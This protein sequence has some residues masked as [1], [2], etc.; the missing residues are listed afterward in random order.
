M[1]DRLSPEDRSRTMRAVKGKGTSLERKLWS[2]LA[3]MKLKGWRKNASCVPG[4]PDVAFIDNKIALFVDG[5][6]WHGCPICNRPMPENN[7]QYWINKIK[8]NVERDEEVNDQ[9]NDL[10]WK[11]FRIWEHE[12]KD[13]SLR[14]QKKIRLYSYFNDKT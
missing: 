10:G 3:G 8:R 13:A 12:L 11:V 6:F 5:C 2:M 14:E 1:P 7:A 4:T 9:L